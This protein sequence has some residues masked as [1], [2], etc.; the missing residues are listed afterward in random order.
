MALTTGPACYGTMPS[1][2]L[3]VCPSVRPILSTSPKQKLVK[4]SDWE[5]CTYNLPSHVGGREVKGQGNTG[6]MNFPV[7]DALLLQDNQFIA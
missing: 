1:V 7:G 2:L 5:T 3:S 6:P 4:T